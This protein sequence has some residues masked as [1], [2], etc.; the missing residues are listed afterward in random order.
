[1]T[2][3]EWRSVE[4]EANKVTAELDDIPYFSVILFSYFLNGLVGYLL[5]D[6]EARTISNSMSD[7][8]SFTSVPWVHVE[9]LLSSLL[10]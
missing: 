3:E 4:I 10:F 9:R 1:M 7:L 6:A 2:E 8:T 5:S